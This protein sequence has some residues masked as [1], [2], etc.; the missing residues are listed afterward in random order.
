MFDS[1]SE[2]KLRR[3]FEAKSASRPDHAGALEGRLLAAFAARYPK[4]EKPSMKKIILRRALIASAVALALGVAACAAPVDL[5]VEV[6]RTLEV[7]YDVGATSPPEPEKIAE[8][9]RAAVKA[10][11]PGR[12]TGHRAVALR[13]AREGD[14]VTLEAELWGTDALHEP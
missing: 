3:L 11:A 10:E 6:G 2:E 8:F 12:P 4:K 1:E 13:V 7:Q 14:A 9:L 5:E